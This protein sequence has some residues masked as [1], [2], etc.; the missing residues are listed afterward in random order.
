[1]LGG[2][3]RTSAKLTTAPPEA[4][5]RA[6]AELERLAEPLRAGGGYDLPATIRVAAGRRAL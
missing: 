3:V 2:L 5:E 1:M 6:R 4:R